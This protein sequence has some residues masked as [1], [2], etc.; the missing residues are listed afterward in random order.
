MTYLKTHRLQ[1]VTVIF[2]SILFSSIA[3]LY[4]FNILQWGRGPD[5]GWFII[6][7]MGRIELVEVYGEAE[8]AGLQAGDQIVGIN[9]H[10]IVSYD[11]LQQ[12]LVREETGNNIYEINRRG[13]ILT[14]SVTN[15]ALGFNTSFLRF[16]LTWLLGIV[17]FIMGAV[18]FFMK[19]GTY[20]SWAF[21]VAMFLSGLYNIFISTSKLTPPW[22]GYVPLFAMA[23][24]PAAILQLA[25][26]FPVERSWVRNRSVLM[27]LPYVLSVGFFIVMGLSGRLITDVPIFIQQAVVLYGQVS[28]LLFWVS[29]FLTYIKNPSQIVRIRARIIL[30]GS[31]LSIGFPAIN[32]IATIFFHYMLLPDPTYSLFFYIFLPLFTGYAIARHNLFDIDVYIKRAVGYVMM[33]A[34]VAMAYFALQTSVRTLVLEPLLG[35]SAEKVYPI[36]F[37]L[38]VVFLFNPLNRTVQGWVDKLFY[39]KKFDYK[40]TVTAVSQTL[41]SLMTLDEVIRQVIHTVRK[42]MFI[43]TTGIVLLEPKNRSC[44]TLFIGDSDNPLDKVKDQLKD[45]SINYDDPLLALLSREKKLI[46]RYD[47]EED[48]KYLDVRESC[49]QRFTEMGATLAIPM[50]HKDEMKGALVLGN[51]K[52]GHFYTREDIDLLTTL[53]SQ[54]AVAI[55]NA[56]LFEENLEKQRMEEELKIAHDIQISMFPDRA[57]EIVGF[58]I[59]GRC[60]PAKEVGGD[61]YDFIEIR[62][63]EGGNRLGIVI[64]D[65]S[66]KGVSGALMMA[67]ARSTCRVLSEGHSSVEELMT[68][69]NR[70]LNRDIKKGM[71]V[72]LIFAE[73]DPVGKTLTFSNAG[74]TQPIICSHNSPGGSYIDTEGD[75]FPLGILQESLYEEKKLQL[76]EGDTVVFYTDGVVEA[77]NARGELYGFERFMASVEEG[78]CLG[79]QALLEKLMA[80]VAC[81]TGDVEQHD[82]ITIVVVKVE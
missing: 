68:V 22:L 50:V 72:A 38:L 25:Q 3:V 12:F 37:A 75:R 56:R 5:F 62:R 53:T 16:G 77:M 66:G 32:M 49:V 2:L 55:V 74:Q 31:L 4:F 27:W 60:I 19:P 26:T 61:F 42:E 81:Y 63:D 73:L 48:S 82:D 11:E 79:A 33:T 9:H 35:E 51:K 21:F 41:S 58:K 76:S 6:D 70:R 59:A 52:S 80:D 36:L 23:F 65:V 1:V 71:F 30:I 28:L 67:A 29:T 15:K 57:P 18:V 14:V 39:R 43:D 69:G 64:G 54:G 13:Q 46:T 20:P 45:V 47:I 17:F 44:Q 78:K 40:A 10:K 24:Q 7:Q 8:R 34:L